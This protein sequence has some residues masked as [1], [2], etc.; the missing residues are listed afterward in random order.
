MHTD[1]RVRRG[2][3]AAVVSLA[4]A[5]TVLIPISGVASAASTS[6][7]CPGVP[8]ESGPIPTCVLVISGPESVQVGVAFT[9]QVLV[10]TDG[11]TVAKSDPCA[12]KVAVTLD[13]NP[14]FDGGTYCRLV[15][16]QRI[17]GDR[18]VH[19]DHPSRNP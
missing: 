9:V 4:L 3:F 1:S 8:S 12:S 13:V 18:D 15:Y 10:T 11:T 16:R 14:A 2:M 6:T 19:R 7:T 17:G 5:A